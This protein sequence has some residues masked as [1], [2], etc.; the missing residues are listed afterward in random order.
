MPVSIT[1]VMVILLSIK[2]ELH[3]WVKTIEPNELYS[4][5]VFLI[6]SAILLPLLPNRGYSPW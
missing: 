6:I 2:P 1:I 3:K 5:I 4:G